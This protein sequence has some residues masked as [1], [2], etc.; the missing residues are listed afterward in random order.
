MKKKLIGS[1]LMIPISDGAFC[2][3]RIMGDLDYAFYDY[4]TSFPDNDL[5]KII[6]KEILFTALVHFK[7]LKESDWQIIGKLPL[8]AR[9]RI[10]PIYFHPDLTN[11]AIRDYT[12]GKIKQTMQYKTFEKGGLQDGGVYNALNIKQRLKDYYDGN[13]YEG[14]LGLLKMLEHR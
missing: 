4:K 10:M 8:D 7:A 14:I 2:Y 9:H 12:E 3:A 5:N 6:H 13:D 11:A 1:I